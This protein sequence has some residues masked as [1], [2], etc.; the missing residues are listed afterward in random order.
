MPYNGPS[1]LQKEQ[2]VKIATD[3]SRVV[4]K[5]TQNGSPIEETKKAKVRYSK[6]DGIF[7]SNVVVEQSSFIRGNEGIVFHYFADEKGGLIREVEMK[8]ESLPGRPTEVISTEALSFD[9]ARILIQFLQ[10]PKL[11]E[12]LSQNVLE[13][14]K[15]ERKAL[16]DD[17][18]RYERELDEV[19]E[20]MLS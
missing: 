1:D 3:F 13:L 16:D 12:S 5:H 18:E 17:R 7:S 11:Y 9:D 10:D 14:R 4:E 8:L 20:Q 15:E 2:A 6:P 19:R